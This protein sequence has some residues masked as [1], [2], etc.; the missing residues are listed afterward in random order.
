MFRPMRRKKQCLDEREA[1][2]I[3]ERNTA[4]TL[5]LL[6]NNGYPY[7]VPLSYVYHDGMLYFHSASSGH[8][9]DA[10]K[11]YDKASFCVIDQDHVVPEQYTTHYKSV[12]AF[13]KVHLMEDEAQRREILTMLAM[14]YCADY[15]HGIE[16]EIDAYIENMAVLAFS[17]EHITGKAAIELM[18]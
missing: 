14:K 6:G 12:V 8:K 15:H 18:R 7:A 13:G 2:A 4:G 11:Q 9:I 3:L 5:A 1:V 16:A 17:I 10:I